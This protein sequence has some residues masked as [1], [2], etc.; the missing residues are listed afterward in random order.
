MGYNRSPL[1]LVPFPIVV[2]VSREVL[3]Q[4]SDIQNTEVKRCLAVLEVIKI[5]FTVSL[6][7]DFQAGCDIQGVS[8]YCSGSDQVP[9]PN[10]RSFPLGI[11]VKVEKSS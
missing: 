5:Q 2:L 9:R 6:S 8:V 1:P 4:C 3:K 10:E 7:N 11:M